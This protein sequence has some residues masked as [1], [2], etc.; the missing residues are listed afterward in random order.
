MGTYVLLVIVALVMVYLFY[1]VIHPE[2]F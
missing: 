2:R 1:A